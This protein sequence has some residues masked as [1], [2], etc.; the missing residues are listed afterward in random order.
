MEQLQNNGIDSNREHHVPMDLT[1]FDTP[2][3]AEEAEEDQGF[4]EFFRDA[5]RCRPIDYEVIDL[6]D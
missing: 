3:A 5:M 4:D 6:I 2:Y 1:A